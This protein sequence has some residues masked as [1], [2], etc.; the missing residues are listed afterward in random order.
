MRL[1]PG[2]QAPLFVAQDI[3]GQRVNLADYQG[4][5]L[6]LSFYR[7][8]VCPL[9]N[10]RTWH[11][12]DRYPE[13]RRHGLYHIAFYESSPQR[14]HQYLD[15]LRAPFPVVADLDRAVY[16]LYRLESSLLGAFYARLTRGS[17]YREAATKR[18]GGNTL[19]SVVQAG[20]AFGRLPADFLI[21][22][23]LRIHTAYYAK[24]AGDFLRF[25]DIDRFVLG[26]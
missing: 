26:A 3:Y 10:L 13:Y 7:A 25:A 12:I 15:R 24:D 16:A 20:R 2:Q 9:C 21:A 17:V 22:P 11:L 18:I 23:G 6:L 14:T 8:A 4:V 19:Q 1:K 5:S